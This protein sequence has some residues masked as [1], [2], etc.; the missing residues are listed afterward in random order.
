M[1]MKRHHEKRRA[2]RIKTGNL[3]KRDKYRIAIENLHKGGM[4]DKEITG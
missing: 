4:T 1:G 2:E 3:C